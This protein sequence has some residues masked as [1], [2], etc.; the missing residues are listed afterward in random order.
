[1]TKRMDS[2]PCIM[3]CNL[4]DSGYTRSHFTWCNGW[5]PEK[6]FGRDWTEFCTTKNGQISLILL[7][8]LT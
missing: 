4:M 2:L 6:Q 7:V 1:M 8:F 3:D 5:I